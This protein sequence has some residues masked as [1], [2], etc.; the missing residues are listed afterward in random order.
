MDLVKNEEEEGK[1]RWKKY[2]QKKFDKDEK[3]R[4]TTKGPRRLIN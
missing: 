2:T 3:K 4:T 1:E